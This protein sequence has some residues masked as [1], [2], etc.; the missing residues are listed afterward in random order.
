[1][2]EQE[3]KSLQQSLEQRI[4]RMQDMDDARLGTFTKTDWV[5][6]IIFSLVVPFIALVLAR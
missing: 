4:S 6:L 5:V 2:S 1:M 3:E